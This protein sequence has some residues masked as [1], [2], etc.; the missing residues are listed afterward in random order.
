MLNNLLLILFPILLFLLKNF[1]PL[2]CTKVFSEKNLKGIKT[3][4]IEEFLQFPVDILFIAISYTIP[5]AI[6]VLNELTNLK[7]QLKLDISEET[8]RQ[9]IEQIELCNKCL[10]NY[11]I[12]DTIM[13]VLLPIITVSTK[14]SIK[15]GDENKRFNQIILTISLY[16][17]S[18]GA[19]I[20][21]LFLYK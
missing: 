2:F 10:F 8:I 14:Y 13:L 15:L 1:F 19:V 3:K 21:S 11:F 12:R 9:I 20:Y 6:D 4:I 7:L 16:A 18:I 5:R 17:I